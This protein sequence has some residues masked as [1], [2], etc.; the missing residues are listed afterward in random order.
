[1]TL[2][3][4]AAIGGVVSSLAV[5]LSLIYLG[6]QTHQAAKHTRALISQ[7]R[8]ARLTDALAAFSDSDRVAARLQVTT[9]APPTLQT[10]QQTQTLMFFQGA[11]AGWSD[12]FE[13]Y[14]EGLLSDDQFADMR[15]IISGVLRPHLA[16]QFWEQWKAGR[17]NTHSAFKAWVD[18][19]IAAPVDVA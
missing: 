8:A 6:V 16:H 4:L 11:F 17:P 1:M 12:V 7:A 3:D 5:A 9:G 10:I 14:R 18:D 2:S 15:V 13:Q 19:A